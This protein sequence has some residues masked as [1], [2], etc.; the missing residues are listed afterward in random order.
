MLYS[1]YHFDSLLL[2]R[3][4]VST[5]V[6]EMSGFCCCFYLFI[7]LFI[8]WFNGP[9]RQ[10]FSLYW[11]VSEREG[12]RQEKWSEKKNPNDYQPHL[13][14]AQEALALLLSKLVGRPGT[15]SYPRPSPGPQ[16]PPPLPPLRQKSDPG[17]N[18]LIL[19]Q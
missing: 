12:E 16:R 19:R 7:Y 6:A 15:E 10:Y 18:P 17:L 5:S 13:L 2:R 14:Q 1:L 9:L 3:Y 8:Y 11:A 4:T